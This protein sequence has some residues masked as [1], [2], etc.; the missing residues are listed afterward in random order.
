MKTKSYA[1]LGA[2]LLA[3]VANSEE[4]K[5]FLVRLAEEDSFTVAET[6]TWMIQLVRT[7]P[8]LYTD[9]RIT[10]KTGN[11]FSLTL[12]FKSDTHAMA[13]LDTPEKMK[14]VIAYSSQ[15]DLK[16]TGEKEVH[17]QPIDYRG[18]YGFYAVITNAIPPQLPNA[19]NGPFKFTTRG[20]VRLTTDSALGFTLRTHVLNSKEYQTLMDYIL[21]FV[22]PAG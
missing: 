7:K 5:Q 14:S 17:F 8:L 10:P 12:Y 2:L 19:T 3:L 11:T 20:M 13:N 4:F 6:K 22:Q 9:I 21:S 15:S 1:C 16:H 18:R